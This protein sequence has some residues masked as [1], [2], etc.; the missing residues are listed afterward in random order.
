MPAISH[1]DTFRRLFRAARFGFAV[2]AGF[3]C[4]Q[5]L[6]NVPSPIP[7]NSILMLVFVALCPPSVLS[8]EFDTE[9][10]TKSFYVLWV[11][12]ALMNAALYATIRGLLSRRLQRPD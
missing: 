1:M 2:A 11:V 8:L 10:G 12:I 7:R 4:Y 3:A 5:L 6:T 9:L